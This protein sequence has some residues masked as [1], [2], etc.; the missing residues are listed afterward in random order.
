MLEAGSR[1][2]RDKLGQSEQTES[3][4]DQ[5]PP[6]W[7]NWQR[8]LS[9]EKPRHEVHA[10]ETNFY[11]DSALKGS[12][13][14]EP[15]GAL[16]PERSPYQLLYGF[17][18]GEAGAEG[19]VYPRYVF[20]AVLTLNG[21]L[22]PKTIEGIDPEHEIAALL[23]LETGARIA[24]GSRTRYMNPT[25]P[26]GSPR[27]ERAHPGQLQR[28]NSAHWI[29]P[30]LHRLRG[31]NECTHF[32]TYPMLSKENAAALTRAAMS[33]NAALWICESEPELAWLL[34]VSAVECIA[35]K[36]AELEQPFDMPEELVSVATALP[37]EERQLLVNYLQK[38]SL[39][40]RKFLEFFKANMPNPPKGRASDRALDWS[41]SGL[42]PL[43]KRIYDM[44][45]KRLHA[46]VHFPAWICRPP[47]RDDGGVVWE[48]ELRPAGVAKGGQPDLTLN[49]F[50][51]L[52]RKS[53][54][55]WWR[56]ALPS[57]VNVVTEGESFWPSV[58]VEQ[59]G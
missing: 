50:F 9:Q 13:G 36:S 5:G 42:K 23:A 44:R 18:D 41:W 4:E 25:D 24:T 1:S 37:D 29:V 17:C 57:G 33:F 27:G 22:Y 35:G 26:S 39:L 40:L 16:S 28:R 47:R 10:I 53:I 55:A 56:A 15:T 49:I 2:Q 59:P 7:T 46:G 38:R 34:L 20:R 11:S 52:V 43:L 14:F 21:S 54:L 3:L 8:F 51:Y 58:L 31:V 45:S 30:G 12:L 32:E 48:Y 19:I 6:A